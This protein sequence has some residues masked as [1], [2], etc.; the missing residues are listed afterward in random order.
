MKT[1]VIKNVSV[2]Y[3]FLF[4]CIN[5]MPYKRLSPAAHVFFCLM[6][7][8]SSAELQLPRDTSGFSVSESC[9][10]SAEVQ[11]GGTSARSTLTITAVSIGLSSITMLFLQEAALELAVILDKVGGFSTFGGWRAF[12]HK[13][14]TGV[15]SDRFPSGLNTPGPSVLRIK[16]SSIKW[17]YVLN[18]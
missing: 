17:H 8:A 1:F 11:R 18:E 13:G 4:S 15:A 9:T 6:N 3:Q 16:S 14:K 2:W 7:Q 5:N 10:L 12:I